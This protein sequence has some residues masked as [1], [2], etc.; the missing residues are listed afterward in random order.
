MIT[1]VT[2]WDHGRIME[3]RSD[4]TIRFCDVANAKL[5]EKLTFKELF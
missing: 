5:S 1:E 3:I 2:L 4:D